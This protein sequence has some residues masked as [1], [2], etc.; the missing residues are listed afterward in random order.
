MLSLVISEDGSH[1][2][3]DS[4]LNEQYHSRHGAIAESQ[5]VF[6]QAGFHYMAALTE[7]IHILEVGFGTGLNALLTVKENKVLQK[8]VHYQALEPFPLRHEIISQLNY[9]NIIGEEYQT[10]FNEMHTNSDHEKLLFPPFFFS[11]N[12]SRI[13]EWDAPVKYNL[14][15]FDAFSPATQPALWTLEIFTKIFHL[16]SDE[17]CLVTYCAKGEVKRT[18]KAAGFKVESLPGPIG[19]REMVRALKR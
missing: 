7:K 8:E 4:V 10:T 2:I 17:A 6:I 1:T 15:Y 18:L 14:V 11:K 12:A 9:C 16:L 19:K 3:S 5:H 13:E